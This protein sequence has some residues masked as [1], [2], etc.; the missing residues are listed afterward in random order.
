MKTITRSILIFIVLLSACVPVATEPSTPPVYITTA[1]KT[2]ATPVTVASTNPNV[3]PDCPLPAIEG[4]GGK[5]RLAYVIQGNLWLLDEG[6]EPVQMIGSGDV[7]QVVLSSDG[8]QIVVTR[9]R[10]ANTMEVWVVDSLGWRELSGDEGISGSIEFISFSSDGQ[11]LAFYRLIDPDRELWVANINTGVRQLVT[12]ENLRSLDGGAF[13]FSAYPYLVT[14]IPGTHQLIYVPV[15]AGQGGDS[16]SNPD[17]VQIVD[18]DTGEQNVLLPI[19]EGGYITYSPDGKIM[20]IA[21]H[22]HVRM[23]RVDNLNEPQTIISYTS[24]CGVPNCYIPQ[25]VWSSDSSSFLLAIPSEGMNPDDF[26]NGLEAPLTVWDISADGS[27]IK[28]LGEIVRVKRPIYFSPD[29][30]RV[31]YYRQES[32][33]NLHIA[34]VNGSQDVAYDSSVE[35]LGWSP[36]SQHFAYQAVQDMPFMNG[37][38]CGL[39]TQLTDVVGAQFLGWL[40]ATRILLLVGTDFYVSPAGG[41]S[42]PLVQ[43][44]EA[45]VYDY[46]LM[47][48]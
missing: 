18:A 9:R 27:S 25:P 3:F 13:A 6:K 17:P 47:P 11:L 37:D 43:I 19:G 29:L 45:V 10:D 31:A 14:W 34:N 16:V 4:A 5:L 48:E 32:A 30:K 33:R 38:I 28:M 26:L 2:L 21:D 23:L 1:T 20:I 46:V 12:R 36:D 8:S 24:I 35:F 22:S 44:G 7:K 41:K 15:L 39:T 40:D 42:V